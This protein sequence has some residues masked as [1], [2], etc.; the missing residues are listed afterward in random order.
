MRKFLFIAIASLLLSC[1][2]TEKESALGLQRKNYDSILEEKGDSAKT[3]CEKFYFDLRHCILIDL[4]VH[5]GKKRLHLWDMQ[6]NKAIWSALV[7]HG[8]GTNPWGRDKSKTNP[9]LSNTPNSHCSS[10]GKYRIGNRGKST[11]G[12]GVNYKLHGLEDS[13]NNAY[14]RTIV[15]H[16]WEAIADR[17]IYPRGTPEGWGCPAVSNTTIEKLDEILKEKQQPVLL[18][19]FTN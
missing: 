3:F 12:I 6:N 18:W 2:K 7:S 9:Q 13:N 15:L 14:R 1:Q 5:S 10:E 11:W 8:C 4:S 19:I 17:E 16:S